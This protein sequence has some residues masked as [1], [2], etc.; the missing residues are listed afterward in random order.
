MVVVYRMRWPS[1][2][3]ART[4]VRVD[5]AALPNLVAGRRIVPELIQHELRPETVADHLIGY[6]ESPDRAAAVRKE[7]ADVRRRLG[8]PGAFDRAAEAVLAE[9]GP[10]GD[11]SAAPS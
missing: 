9:I 2:L 10:T 7:L 5:H 8:E 1:Y 3:L 11:E 4:L 6:L